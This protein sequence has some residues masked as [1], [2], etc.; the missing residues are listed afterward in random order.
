MPDDDRHECSPKCFCI[1][2]L[3]YVDEITH[4]KVWIHKGPEELCQ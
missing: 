3:D 4:V 1:P 2:R